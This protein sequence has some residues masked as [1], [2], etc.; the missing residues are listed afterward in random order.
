MRQTIVY[1]HGFKSSSQSRKATELAVAIR[2]QQR[3]I[4]YHCPDLSAQPSAALMQLRS[5]CDCVAAQMLTIVGSSVGGFYAVVL[6]ETLGCRAVLLNPAIRAH[7]S[8][9]LH[10]G[11]QTNLYTGEHFVLTAEDI[12]DLSRLFVARISRPERY[13]LIAEMADELLDTRDAITYFAGAK[14][15]IVEGGDHELKSF[16]QHIAAV[17]DFADGERDLRKV[18]A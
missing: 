14:Q 7:E 16:P 18:V 6:A 1:A 17:L 4:D 12:A 5:I 15:I 9:A 8:L 2:Q 3:A 10:L 11:P 13:F